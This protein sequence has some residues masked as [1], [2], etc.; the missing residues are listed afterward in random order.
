MLRPVVD[1]VTAKDVD[2]AKGCCCFED[3]LAAVQVFHCGN[4][5]DE[6][7]PSHDYGWALSDDGPHSA[8]QADGHAN[9][10]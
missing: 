10:Y 8:S 7:G 1:Q 6:G 3:S 5:L 2:C 9:Q 4:L